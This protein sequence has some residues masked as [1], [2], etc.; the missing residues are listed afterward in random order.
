MKKLKENM[1]EEM[2][3]KIFME[4]YTQYMTRTSG[5]VKPLD[6]FGPRKSGGQGASLTSSS[7]ISATRTDIGGQ[8]N[9]NLQHFHQ[10]S[11]DPNDNYEQTTYIYMKRAEKK[12]VD[13]QYIKKMN[14]SKKKL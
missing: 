12:E 7:I 10:Q 14:Q 9:G 4:K 3:S 2:S 8:S 6:Q 5:F 13:Q 11:E 1:P